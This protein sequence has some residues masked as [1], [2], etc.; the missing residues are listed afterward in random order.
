MTAKDPLH[1]VTL[2]AIL[3]A[4]VERLGWDGLAQHVDVRCFKHEPS[5]K[6]SLTFL[7]KTPWAR[8]KVEQLYLQ[9]LRQQK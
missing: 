5:I 1:G 6:S 4:L 8:A 3:T 2:Q 7:R 9:Q